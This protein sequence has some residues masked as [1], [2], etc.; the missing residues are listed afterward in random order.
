MTWGA[1]P[2]THDL[3][4]WLINANKPPWC[5]QRWPCGRHYIWEFFAVRLCHVPSDSSV[6]LSGSA[7][8]CLWCS[9]FNGQTSLCC[10]FLVCVFGLF[11]SMQ[12]IH[13]TLNRLQLYWLYW[14]DCAVLYPLWFFELVTLSP[15]Y[16]S[17]FYQTLSLLTISKQP[18]PN[19]GMALGGCHV[20]VCSPHP[21]PL[22]SNPKSRTVHYRIYQYDFFCYEWLR[23]FD[24]RD[25]T[26]SG[27]LF[28]AVILR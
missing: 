27:S 16:P 7:S 9:R 22:D 15:S 11:F 1:P 2:A 24:V 14:S 25:L 13:V 10:V 28:S 23:A 19:W 3:C 17:A 18:K 20:S 8:T 21:R 26:G 5:V 12:C 6:W 4:S